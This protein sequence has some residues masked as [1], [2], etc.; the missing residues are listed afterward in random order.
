M[1]GSDSGAGYAQAEDRPAAPPPRSCR[2]AHPLHRSR[3]WAT[4][5]QQFDVWSVDRRSQT[6]L[7]YVDAAEF[8]RLVDLGYQPVVDPVQ[9]ATLVQPDLT[10]ARSAAP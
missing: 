5:A 6:A 2:R 1:P 7:I 4:L 8:A 9:T 10:G 3:G